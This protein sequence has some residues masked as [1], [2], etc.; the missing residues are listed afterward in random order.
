[1]TTTTTT[2]VVSSEGESGAATVGV[3]DDEARYALPSGFFLVA[4]V[5][6]STKT[7]E[8]KRKE[9]LIRH[10][11]RTFSMTH[12]R[13]TASPSAAPSTLRSNPISLHRQRCGPTCRST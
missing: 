8:R 9:E 2:T 12:N 3:A 11:V 6:A 7:L 1:M 13:S 4:V 10:V 5:R